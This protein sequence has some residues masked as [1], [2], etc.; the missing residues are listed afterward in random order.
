M[1]LAPRRARTRAVAAAAPAKPV[2]APSAAAPP[3][4]AA[5]VQHGVPTL[6]GLGIS[7]WADALVAR[8]TKRRT[9]K[10]AKRATGGTAKQQRLHANDFLQ[11]DE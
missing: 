8:V 10:A 9:G 6:V 2:A 7:E 3:R 5:Q 1:P 11:T 4:R